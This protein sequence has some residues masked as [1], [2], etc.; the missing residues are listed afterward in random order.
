[1]SA[2]GSKDFFGDSWQSRMAF[3]LENSKIRL[4]LE[5][6]FVDVCLGILEKGLETKENGEGLRS[7]R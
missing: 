7:S 2:P 3:E 4:I 6:I 1:M 5:D